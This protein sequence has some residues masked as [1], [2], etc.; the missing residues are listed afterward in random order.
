[1][2]VGATPAAPPVLGS[3][4]VVAPVSGRVLVRRPGSPGFVALSVGAD[5]P[6]G[7]TVDARGGRVSVTTALPG[8][9]T[10]TGQFYGG[11]FVLTQTATGTTVE[12]LAGGS[13]TGCPAAGH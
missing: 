12:T 6:L 4:G 11:E 13:F 5:I 7:A 8:G 10:E 3:R 9:A 1:Q 2:G